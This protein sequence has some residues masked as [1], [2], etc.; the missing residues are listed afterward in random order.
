MDGGPFHLALGSVANTSAVRKILAGEYVHNQILD[1]HISKILNITSEVVKLVQ[2]NQISTH[3]SG[4][5]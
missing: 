4:E 5:D 2:V 3:I 1:P